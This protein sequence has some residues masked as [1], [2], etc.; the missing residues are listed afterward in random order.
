MSP[1]LRRRLPL[2]AV[3][4][5]GLFL[6]NSD[7]FVQR[8]VLV[9]RLP[10]PT[11]RIARVEIQLYAEDGELV[12]REEL[13]LPGGAPAEIQQEL[14]LK[15]GRYMGRVFLKDTAGQERQRTRSLE[16]GS[17]ERYEIVLE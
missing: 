16:I 11:E 15:R 17:G 13:S 1:A 3:V 2:L 9:W 14:A 5:L 4:A 6:W 10:E 7:L 8:R 12:K